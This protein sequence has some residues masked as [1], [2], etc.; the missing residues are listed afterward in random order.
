MTVDE[1]SVKIS[2]AADGAIE[3]LEG[4]SQR[5]QTVTET[6]EKKMEVKVDTDKAQ[7]NMEF[8][9]KSAEH[10]EDAIKDRSSSIAN[11]LCDELGKATDQGAGFLDMLQAIKKGWKSIAMNGIVE[12]AVDGIGWV[13]SQLFTAQEQ[14]ALAEKERQ[15][16][17]QESIRL[18]E[19]SLARLNSLEKRYNELA[20]K[21][22]RT[23]DESTEMVSIQREL[24]KDYSIEAKGILSTAEAL[25]VYNLKIA[26]TRQ[27]DLLVLHTKQNMATFESIETMNS[28]FDTAVQKAKDFQT[29]YELAFASFGGNAEEALDFVDIAVNR[30]S[31]LFQNKDELGSSGNEK[32]L[33]DM[34]SKLFE[35][36]E[37]NGIQKNY[38]E[39][40]K[41]AA[42]EA[43]REVSNL[44]PELS[45]WLTKHFNQHLTQMA[46]DGIEVPQ[47]L[48]A[49][50]LNALQESFNL[51]QYES[52]DELEANVRTALEGMRSALENPENQEA[53]ETLKGYMMAAKSGMMLEDDDKE[54]FAE[55]W[56][57]VFG[58]DSQLVQSLL[59]IKDVSA[60]TAR[61]T[62]A[63]ALGFDGLAENADSA[64]ET[65][66]A[67]AETVQDIGANTAATYSTARSYIDQF[68]GSIDDMATAVHRLKSQ[69]EAIN[70]VKKFN[71]T[72][73]TATPNSKK[74]TEAIEQMPS[75][76]KAAG[77][78]FDKASYNAA[79]MD[80][81][82]ESAKTG[83]GASAEAI[84]TQLTGAKYSLE[85]MRQGIIDA[86]GGSINVNTD[87]LITAIDDAIN[88]VNGLLSVLALVGIGPGAIDTPSGGRG[89]G[90]GGGKKDDA[91]KA[92]EEAARAAE[93][94]RKEAIQRDY[95][96]IE[97]KRHMNE[98]TLEEELALIEKI[99]RAH[100]LN[101]EEIME[102]EEKVYDLKQE[103][104]E[105]D[106]ES[107]D[108]L[109]DGV[110]TALEN[111]YEAMRDAE[112][113]RLDSSREAWEQWRDDSVQA[114]EDQITALEKLSDTE[115]REKKDAEEL[116][117]IEK[118]R[119]EIE[120]EQD[121][122]NRMKLEQ[123]LQSALDSREERLRKL[124]LSDQKDALREEID[125][126]ND[127]AD[128]QISALDKEQEGIEAAYEER[129][130]Q[131]ALNAEA[132]KLILTQNQNEIMDLLN[133]YVPE[134][135]AL[136]KSMGEKLLEGF[137]SKVGGIVDWFESFNA[138][139][140][141]MQEQMAAISNAA[142][143]SFYQ[144]AA[145][146]ANGGGTAAA[147]VTVNQTVQFYEPVESPSQV[148]RRMEDVNDA[149]GLMLG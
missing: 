20:T 93:E 125:R 113:Q 105:R 112:L 25:E 34:L 84:V 66:N 75:A 59:K 67:T 71:D 73:K 36:N 46:I 107:I 45:D 8:L 64:R 91:A 81:K 123:Q 42:D 32:S 139:I 41:Q 17:L 127:K 137:Q 21:R 83:V 47:E 76:C 132:E 144:G 7:K 60:E 92:A 30:T 5:I 72:L 79:N 38:V 82:I 101:A 133:E 78:A 135:D 100:Q 15:R 10:L 95:D 109:A 31:D 51:S 148:A 87:P 90:G 88:T 44:T 134:Y 140:V 111:R 56:N 61:E 39:L 136:G 53:V 24:A 58:E 102:W 114:I 6:L 52:F 147:G 118:L 49:G 12:L 99:R 37:M 27:Q 65:L 1:M 14:A 33:T 80:K 129:L 124:A 145:E 85:S 63:F 126:I 110:V 130:K 94:A 131:A 43:M 57:D 19:D 70:T 119:R 141:Q 108:T 121:D 103:I 104:R 23:L 77:I 40:M 48:A 13:I 142:A 86:S 2:I 35:Q 143:D 26:E 68:N 116:R 149:L 98:I 50:L 22:V 18:E 11:D 117:K 120:Y 28:A 97:H 146:R 54:A 9:E 106:A 3:A 74:Y 128:E 122:Y 55:T 29:A 89:G 16:A 96:Q 4:L 62:L 138:G 115:D 69:T